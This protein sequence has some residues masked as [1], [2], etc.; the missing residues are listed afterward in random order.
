MQSRFSRAHS[1]DMC[2]PADSLHSHILLHILW[3]ERHNP[4]ESCSITCITTHQLCN[5][6]GLPCTLVAARP[7]RNVKAG[8]CSHIQG[9][10]GG[11]RGIITAAMSHSFYH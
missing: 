11:L 5:K 8:F 10:I 4:G 1:S 9:A 3:S 6:I 2:A 7:S